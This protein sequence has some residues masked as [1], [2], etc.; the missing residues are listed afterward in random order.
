M[1]VEERVV[2]DG[3]G[4]EAEPLHGGERGEGVSEGALGAMGV[5]EEVE[6]VVVG[7]EAECDERAECV[8]GGLRGGGGATGERGEDG[9]R[10]LEGGAD[11]DAAAEGVE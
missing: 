5:H 8:E 3:V 10:S 7:V 2:G 11:A 6:G 1:R 9:V 4:G